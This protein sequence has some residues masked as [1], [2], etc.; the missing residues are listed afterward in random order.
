MKVGD[1]FIGEVYDI[2]RKSPQW[3]RMVFVVT[4]DQHGG[5][6][7]HRPPPVVADNNF[8][9]NPGP[10]PDYK[11]LGFRVPCVAMGPFAAARVEHAGPYAHC[12]GNCCV[13]GASR[14]AVNLK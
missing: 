8:N 12:S 5:F 9:P 4:F 13:N 10:H 7:D 14:T 3:D 6:Y 2:L 11:Q 1:A